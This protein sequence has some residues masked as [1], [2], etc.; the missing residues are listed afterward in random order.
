MYDLIYAGRDVEEIVRKAYPKSEIKDASDN[1]HRERF[2]LEIPDVTENE[3]YPFAIKE[4]FIGCCFGFALYF[5]SLRFPES[6]SEPGKHKETEA[7]IMK[8]I[9]LS[10][11]LKE[12]E[13]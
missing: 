1:I 4:G 2:E 3:F 9:E 12:E 10:K 5:E 13:K 6:K 7:R 8:W 11:T